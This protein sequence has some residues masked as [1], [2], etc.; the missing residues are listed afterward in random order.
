MLMHTASPTFSFHINFF[1]FG[2]GQSLTRTSSSL[3]ALT[4]DMNIVVCVYDVVYIESRYRRVV[5]LQ[6]QIGTVSVVLYS[7]TF[8][9]VAAVLS[10]IQGTA[11]LSGLVSM[12]SL[13]CRLSTSRLL[14]LTV[15]SIVAFEWP[16][17]SV[18]CV[19]DCS[20]GC[21][22][23]VPRTMLYCYCRPKP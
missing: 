19:M 10:V 5:V 18:C 1:G 20:T 17:N 15:R 9:F 4:C 6:F 2:G 11:C 21:R 16:V 12:S 23:D 13:L 8:R 3:S 14:D 22:C 7:S